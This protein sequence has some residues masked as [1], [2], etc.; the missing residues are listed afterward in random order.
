MIKKRYPLKNHNQEKNDTKVYAKIK[1]QHNKFKIEYEITADLSQYNFPKET[2]QQRANELW[3]D[4]CF[5]LFIANNSSQE[6]YEI[7]IS[8][9]TEWNTY[10]FESYKKEMQESNKFSVPSIQNQQSNNRYSFSFEM[11]FQEDI[12][13]KKLLINLA[14]ILLDRDGVRQFYSINRREKLPN[15]HDRNG[16]DLLIF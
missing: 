2:K 4:T 12:F 7:N 5:E 11:N 3:R 10:H 6:Y 9:S 15:F 8:S 14:V 16:F 1:L 13:E